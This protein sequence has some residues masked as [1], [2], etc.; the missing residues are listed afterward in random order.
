MPN[1]SFLEAMWTVDCDSQSLEWSVTGYLTLQESAA[2]RNIVEIVCST[3]EQM[4]Y[5][6]MWW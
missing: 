4:Y 5:Q 1:T 3:S 2:T 6:I